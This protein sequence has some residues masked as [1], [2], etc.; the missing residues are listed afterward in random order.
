V[1]EENV[2]HRL[3]GLTTD[4]SPDDQI[5]WIKKL[6]PRVETL[7]ILYS[8]RSRRTVEAIARAAER[9]HVRVEA[10]VA[11]KDQFGKAVQ[12]LSDRGCDG[13]LMIA[14][15]EVYDS[16]NAQSLLL[17]GLRG[18]KPVWAFSA[19]LVKA[20][21]FAGLYVDYSSMAD[22]TVKTVKRILDGETPS[23]IGLVYPARPRAALNE[24]TSE[25]I[26][27]SIGRDALESLAMRFGK[28]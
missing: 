7:G 25:M 3:A 1:T 9:K 19:N 17:W 26:G 23:K 27:V 5:R 24:R 15:A 21:A 20:G 16:T 8:E 12:A 4:I 13:A 14:D 11:T 22:Q 10:I 28:Q 18:Q 2:H 6:S